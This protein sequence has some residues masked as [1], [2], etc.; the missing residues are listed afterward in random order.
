MNFKEI[1]WS[2]LGQRISYHVWGVHLVYTD[3]FLVDIGAEMMV[4]GSDMFGSWTMFE[5][6]GHLNCTRVILKYMAV[7]FR[8]TV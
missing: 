2:R 8:N 7:N 1:L 5:Y 4:L 6:R 3:E